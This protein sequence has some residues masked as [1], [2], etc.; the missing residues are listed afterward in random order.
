M[1]KVIN[2]YVDSFES[3][4]FAFD[5]QKERMTILGF[6]PQQ[7]NSN[8]AKDE[9]GIER[10]WFQVVGIYESAYNRV[11][12]SGELHTN[13][14]STIKTIVVKFKGDHLKKYGVSTTMLK[15]F[16][17]ENYIGKK[18]LVLPTTEEKQSKKQLQ[19]KEGKNISVP[20]PNQTECTVLDDFDLWK[21]CGMA[22]KSALENK[23][24]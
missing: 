24:A 1:S 11:D 2:A 13:D 6:M 14:N 15:N 10:T 7:C 9:Q 22:D 16:L 4:N 21:F 12:E 23:K 3:K 18:M 20:L 19:N 8:S 5:T 17:D